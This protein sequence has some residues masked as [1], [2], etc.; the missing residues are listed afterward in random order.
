MKHEA[1]EQAPPAKPKDIIKT[2][3]LAYEN[4]S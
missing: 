2:R 3:L 1:I 4:Y